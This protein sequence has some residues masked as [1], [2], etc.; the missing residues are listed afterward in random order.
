MRSLQRIHLLSS[1]GLL[2]ACLIAGYGPSA[3]RAP[4]EISL[5]TVKFEVLGQKHLTDDDVRRLGSV[6]GVKIAVRLRLTNK[7]NQY[8]KYLSVSGTVVPAGYQLFRDIGTQEWKS[9]S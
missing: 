3:R 5:A 4:R 9:T 1:A 8:V 2:V 7:G 6:Y